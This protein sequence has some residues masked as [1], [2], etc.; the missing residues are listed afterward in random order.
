[1]SATVIAEVGAN[2]HNSVFWGEKLLT[3]LK[4][5]G[6]Q[7]VKFQYWKAEDVWIV[8]PKD[9]VEPELGTVRELIEIAQDMGFQAGCSVLTPKGLKDILRGKPDFLKVPSAAVGRK[10]LQ[11]A[12]R[13]TCVPK[14]FGTGYVRR[15]DLGKAAAA[16]GAN[17][18]LCVSQYPAEPGDYGLLEHPKD[19][20]WGVSD[21]T[22]GSG[23]A[24]AAV[25]LGAAWVE[26]HVRHPEAMPTRDFGPHVL[27]PGD[28]GILLEAIEAAE[29]S[30]GFPPSS[31]P[32]LRR[33]DPFR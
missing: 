1:M 31:M 6:I 28:L 5:A 11:E 30:V 13:K 16:F 15:E 23:M 20:D 22:A 18:L 4:N 7:M 33:V 2:H 24:C 25:T 32:S 10:D 14:F 26:K 27:T 17:P 8:P 21:H 12:M 29:E 3:Q 19:L 9:C